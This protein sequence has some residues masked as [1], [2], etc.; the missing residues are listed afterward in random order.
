MLSV[1]WLT[2][3]EADDAGVVAHVTDVVNRAYKLAEIDL[4]T[5][6][7]PRTDEADT[8]ESIRKGE[9]AVA[10]S[11]GVIVGAIRARALDAQTWW[12]GAL[13][14][15]PAYAGQGVGNALVGFVEDQASAS[16]AQAMRLELLEADPPL[17]HLVRLAAWYDRRGYRVVGRERVAD[18]H[19]HDALSL[20]KACDVVELTRELPTSASPPTG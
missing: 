11:D 7:I 18:R 3:T 5:K 2:A 10:E 14:V 8:A 16:G 1:R 17:D 12:F 4:W 6:D 19:P 15:D 13:G 9:T 20:T